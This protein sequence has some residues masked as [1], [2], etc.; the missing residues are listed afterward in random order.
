ML[1]VESR[2][3]DLNVERS[4]RTAVLEALQ[5][6]GLVPL[7]RAARLQFYEQAAADAGRARELER[8]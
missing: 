8:A 3:A 6:R 1:Y 2:T 5:R 4:L 7:I